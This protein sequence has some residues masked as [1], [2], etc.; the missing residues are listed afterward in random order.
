MAFQ[1]SIVGLVAYLGHELG[2]LVRCTI[3]GKIAPHLLYDSRPLRSYLSENTYI[4]VYRLKNYKIEM[5][6]INIVDN[7]YERKNSAIMR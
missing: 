3:K 7:E 5:N 4:K 2:F 1:S 6:H